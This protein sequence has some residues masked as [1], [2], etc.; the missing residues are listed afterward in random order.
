[1]TEYY[2]VEESRDNL[3]E[4]INSIYMYLLNELNCYRIKQTQA[5]YSLS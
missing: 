1:M 2:R 5:L 4:E 3:R